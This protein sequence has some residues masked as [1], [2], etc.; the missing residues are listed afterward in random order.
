MNS[1][2]NKFWARFILQVHQLSG[3]IDVYL[4]V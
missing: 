4:K 3:M 1:K 2:V